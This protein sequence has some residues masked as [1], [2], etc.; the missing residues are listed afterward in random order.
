RE[1]AGGIAVDVTQ[2]RVC[3]VTQQGSHDIDLVCWLF[4][5]PAGV[6]ARV[7]TFAHTGI[8]VEDHGAAI[9]D[10]PDGCIISV[11]A[12]TVAKPGFTPRIDVLT[13]RGSFSMED[14][15]IVMWAVD[16][17]DNPGVQPEGELHSARTVAVTDTS[18]HEAII[19]DFV[20][21][22]RTDREVLIPGPSARIA[23]DVI[24]A[25]YRA[26]EEGRRISLDM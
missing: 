14:D 25:I 22:V 9:L 2:R 8:D 13:E 16:G 7:G 1:I 15:C 23:T 3:I 24:L 4:G 18:G 19:R 12:S 10:L 6:V 5:A 26:S 17:L 21:A 20:D 11:V